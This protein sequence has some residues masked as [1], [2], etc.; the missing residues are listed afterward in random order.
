M[1]NSV[2]KVLFALYM[3][4]FLTSKQNN[5]YCCHLIRL[6]MTLRRALSL[7]IRNS[8]DRAL[9]FLLGV[10]FLSGTKRL[11]N[12]KTSSSTLGDEVRWLLGRVVIMSPQSPFLKP[13]FP[14]SSGRC[15][16]GYLQPSI[17]VTS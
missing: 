14:A 11:I 5:C 16:R 13:Q 1:A 4:S 2:L 10:T 7:S 8:K 17:A 9:Q 3:L 15:H 6:Y 12:G